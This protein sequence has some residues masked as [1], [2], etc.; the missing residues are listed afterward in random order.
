M[1]V[2]HVGNYKAEST[3]GDDQAIVRYAELLPV[4]GFEV[5]LW[6]FTPEVDA[7][8]ERRV[9]DVRIFDVPCHRRRWQNV[10]HVPKETRYFL[11]QRLQQVDLVHLHSVFRPENLWV[12]RLGSRYIVSPH[13]GYSPQVI[14]GRNRLL[15]R[16]WISLW[17]RSYLDRARAVHAVSPPE[18]KGLH[19]F[20]VKVPVVFIPNGVDEALLRRK[21][22]KPHKASAWVYLGRLAVEHKGLDLLVKGY[23][24]LYKQRGG[25]LPPLVLA[26][27]DFRGGKKQLEKLIRSLGVAESVLLKGPVFGEDKWNLL[28]QAQ[29]FVHT[30][31]WE[32]MPLAM[33]EALACGRPVL[34]TPETNC[35]QYIEEYRAGWIVAGTP[36]AIAS[37]LDAVLESST[38]DL[39]AAGDQARSLAADNFSWPSLTRQ[40]AEV[41]REAVG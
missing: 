15:K 31:R 26:G 37:G 27:P 8:G 18:V 34:I 13:G 7:V 1:R 19:S 20:G 21:L 36:E 3:N 39:D 14:R 5:E 30:S 16:I 12:G 23:A 33:L 32:G 9:D 10:V 11:E 17:E 29:L 24:S 41:Y 35:E 2:A 4:N 28:A 25:K 6:H 40:L 22:S 38:Q